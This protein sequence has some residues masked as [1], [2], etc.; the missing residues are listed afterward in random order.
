MPLGYIMYHLNAILPSDI[1]IRSIRQ[2]DGGSTCVG[3]MRRAETYEYSIY[4]FKNPFWQIWWLIFFHIICRDK[5]NE[6]V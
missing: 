3:L 1:V 6:V 2:V 4:R 5:L